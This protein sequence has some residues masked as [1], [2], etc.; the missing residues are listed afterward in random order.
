MGNF[1]RR[2]NKEHLCD[3]PA[4]L[5][6][7]FKDLSSFSSAGHISCLAELNHL[8]NFGKGLYVEH[9]CEIILNLGQQF[10]KCYLKTYQTLHKAR[11]MP[12]KN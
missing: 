1:G 8:G 5:Y 4:V 9:L 6:M 3:G 7:L 12:D 10:R 2:P 11:R